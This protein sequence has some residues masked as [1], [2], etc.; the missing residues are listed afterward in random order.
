MNSPVHPDESWE[1]W[2]AR[3]AG[4]L[5]ALTE[6]GW[7]TATTHLTPAPAAPEST[8]ER[9]PRTWRRLLGRA[10]AETPEPEC[11]V[12]EAFLQ[13]RLLEGVLA[14]EC[15]ADT[16][17]AGLSDL[18]DEQVARLVGL[19]WEQD[20]DQPDLSQTFAPTDSAGAAALLA[21]SLREVLGA[22]TPS[23][24]DLRRAAA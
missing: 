19:G 6:G 1:S 16:E 13:A 23:D 22:K 10:S 2:S 12:P 17:F 21:D 9:T 14:L 15:I 24:V 11:S 4:D 18:S 3:L 5:G 7:L 20:G 8:P